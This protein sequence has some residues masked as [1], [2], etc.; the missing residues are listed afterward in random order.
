MNHAVKGLILVNP[1]DLEYWLR[2]HHL[3]H[4]KEEGVCQI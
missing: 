1:V 3:R 4:R 2:D